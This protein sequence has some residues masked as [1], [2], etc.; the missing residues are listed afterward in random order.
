MWESK[1]ENVAEMTFD[2]II[3]RDFVYLLFF[4]LFQSIWVELLFKKK[5]L[6]EDAFWKFKENAFAKVS[7]NIYIENILCIYNEIQ[8]KWE[9]KN[10]K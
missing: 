5:I 8:P 3:E 2:K 6:T 9:R 10:M 4:I 7:F 1:T